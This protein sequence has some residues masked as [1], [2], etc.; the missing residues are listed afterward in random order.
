MTSTPNEPY[1]DEWK[2]ADLRMDR[3][4]FANVPIA[5]KNPF[6]GKFPRQQLHSGRSYGLSVLLNPALEEY[7]CTNTDSIGFQ[8]LC[9]VTINLCIN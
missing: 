3:L 7:H 4:A 5:G 6:L 2:K 9:I 1:L 8:V